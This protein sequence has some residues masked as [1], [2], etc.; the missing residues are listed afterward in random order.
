MTRIALLGIVL[1]GFSALTAE[2][3]AQ[4]GILGY[5]A[6]LLASPATI[7]VSTDVVIALGLAVLWMWG[8]AQERAL[9]FWPYAVATTL[10]GSV[11][12]LSYLVH[13]EVRGLRSAPVRSLEADSAT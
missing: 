11:G 5:I 12:L 9:P 10:L 1:L 8:D 2:V 13:R 4:Y 6:Q 7:H 3:I